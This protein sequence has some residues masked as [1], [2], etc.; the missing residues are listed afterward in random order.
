MS[1]G[2][3]TPQPPSMAT[4]SVLCIPSEMMLQHSGLEHW[5]EVFREHSGTSPTEIVL[6]GVGYRGPTFP[7]VVSPSGKKAGSMSRW[8]SEAR[9]AVG[10]SGIVWAN[11]IMDFG[12][13]GSD[14][15]GIRN[16][17]GMKRSQIC[18]SNPTSQ[19]IVQTVVRELLELGVDGIVVD[20]S[21]LLPNAGAA[22]MADVN[23]YCFC[24]HCLK[25]LNEEKLT[26]PIQ[27]L[28]GPNSI[29]RLALKDAGSSGT[30]HIDPTARQI[31]ER[32]S[33]TLVLTALGQRYIEGEVKDHLD[34]AGLLLRYFEARGRA[35]A[36]SLREITRPCS[37]AQ[38][39][40]AIVL[41]SVD[42][43]QS[44]QVTA[45]D[46][47][48]AAAADELWVSDATP[49]SSSIPT[50][51][52]LAARSSYSINSFFELVEDANNVV[53]MAG[54]EHF[55]RR[56]ANTSKRLGAN[57]L[58][59]ASAYVALNSPQYSGFV[60]VP[61]MTDDHLAIVS[62]LTSQITGSA[63][64]PNLLQQF[65]TAVGAA[66]TDIIEDEG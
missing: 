50:L 52:Y 7:S 59:P 16:Q 3:E 12:F 23:V 56:L 51:C 31:V 30:A 21:E 64:P 48:R 8:I 28:M 42:F 18:I 20:G 27:R 2:S 62:S 4:R 63:V 22:D 15:L 46:V 45:Q 6:P 29:Y 66:P 39:R 54:I 26:I 40:S 33:T 17:Y 24:E 14:Y 49:D 44:Q 5:V 36:R 13:L 32:D 34:D 37:E 65:R 10:E 19:R 43:D 47:S 60:G 53:T 57:T 25:L 38:R 61:L 35:V 58:S 41:N 9:Q 1:Q 55:L 11:M